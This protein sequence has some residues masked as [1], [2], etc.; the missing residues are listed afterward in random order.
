MVGIIWL[1]NISSGSYRNIKITV[2]D[3]EHYSDINP[4]KP[5]TEYL[6]DS[7]TKKILSRTGST[8][9]EPELTCFE[10]AELCKAAAAYMFQ[11]PLSVCLH[12]KH[13]SEKTEFRIVKTGHGKYCI[14]DLYNLVC[15]NA[16]YFPLKTFTFKTQKGYSRADLLTADIF[17]EMLNFAM[18]QLTGTV[19]TICYQSGG[20]LYLD[21]SKIIQ[22]PLLRL[23]LKRQLSD[24]AGAYKCI[25]SLYRKRKTAMTESEKFPSRLKLQKMPSVKE[26]FEAFN[27]RQKAILTLRISK[28]EALNVT[29]RLFAGA[30]HSQLT[31][32]LFNLPFDES[33]KKLAAECLTALT[34]YGEKL[35]E[36]GFLPGRQYV[37]YLC[38]YDIISAEVDPSIRTSLSKKAELARKTA[39]DF[40]ARENAVIAYDGTAFTFNDY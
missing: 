40:D 28:I 37:R 2:F 24:C 16:V 10:L 7:E 38:V 13:S 14:P 17:C 27:L 8:S 31:Q 26:D 4:E 6:V 19:N 11:N 34:E 30:K 22:N 5:N 35:A 23:S 9:S 3:G 39:I 21:V 20:T 33:M 12:F 25:C 32:V 1:K 18:L 29:C 15:G 36:C